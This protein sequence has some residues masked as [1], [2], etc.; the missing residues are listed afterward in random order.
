MPAGQPVAE[1]H[2]VKMLPKAVK[3]SLPIVCFYWKRGGDL[4]SILIPSSAE[5]TLLSAAR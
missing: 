3:L 4:L 2:T 5:W 1:D